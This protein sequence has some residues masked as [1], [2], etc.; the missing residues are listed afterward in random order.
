MAFGIRYLDAVADSEAALLRSDQQDI[1]LAERLRWSGERLVSS[2]RGYLLSGDRDLARLREA[3]VGFDQILSSLEARAQTATGAGLVQSVERSATRFRSAQARLVAQRL[4]GVD[5]ETLVARFEAELVPLRR[6]LIQSID[7]LVDYKEATLQRAYDDSDAVRAKLANWT[8]VLL[9]VLVF[10][11][12]GVSWYFSHQLAAA[13]RE[14]QQALEAARSAIRSR[15]DLMGMVAHDL[16]NPLGAITLKAGLLRAGFESSEVQKQAKAI[17][18][19]AMR[20]EFL[21]KTMLDVATIEAGKFSIR[22]T[23]CDAQRLLHDT[24]EMFT[25]VAQSKHVELKATPGEPG[26]TIQADRE[27]IVEVLSNLVGNALKFTPPGGW[28]AI[29]LER[30]QDGIWFSVSDSGPGIAVADLPH[31][32][33]RFWKHE[34]HGAKGTGLGLFIARNIIEAHGGRIWAENL[35]GGGARFR[36]A[37]PLGAPAAQPVAPGEASGRPA[38]A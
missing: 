16:R 15:D 29:S 11:G 4:E 14:Q 1:V 35:P 3:E 5:I 33:E 21:I 6:G 26:L 22:P 12:L 13:Y 18:S 28:V 7:D 10:A 19:I 25:N 34:L 2:G 24:L 32:F 38:P 36:F 20:M 17:E 31:L 30:Q 37:I 27:R 9:G 23:P 8:Q